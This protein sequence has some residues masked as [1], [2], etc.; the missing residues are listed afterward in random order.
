[1]DKKWGKK[2]PLSRRER[3]GILLMKCIS[4]IFVRSA[5]TT[6]CTSALNVYRSVKARWETKIYPE[7]SRCV[8]LS[9]ISLPS[10]PP[11]ERYHHRSLRAHLHRAGTT[12]RLPS[13]ERNEGG[14][15]KEAGE[16]RNERDRGGE[17]CERRCLITRIPIRVCSRSSVC[18]RASERALVNAVYS[19]V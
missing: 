4:R 8:H 10:L 17:T 3:D 9:L 16:K 13:R 1:M 19:C 18:W 2:V 6:R 11:R 5:T 7:L 12:E 15:G 14:R